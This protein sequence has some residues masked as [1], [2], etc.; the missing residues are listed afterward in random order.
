LPVRGLFRVAAMMTGSAAMV[1]IR[2]IQHYLRAL[3]TQEAHKAGATDASA[4]SLSSV[5]S[6]VSQITCFLESL[7]IP[8]MSLCAQN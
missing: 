6:F 3:S 2:R 7:F 5:F 1:N 8:K 4:A